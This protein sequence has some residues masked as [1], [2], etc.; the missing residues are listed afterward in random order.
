M[1]QS[2][3]FKIKFPRIDSLTRVKLAILLLLAL[4]ALLSNLSYARL[5]RN[6]KPKAAGQDEVSL[7]EKRFAELRAALPQRGVVGYI[8]DEP[9][10]NEKIKKY[11]LAQYAL[12]P[13]IVVNETDR[14]LVVGNFNSPDGELRASDKLVPFKRFENGVV[15]FV[16]AAK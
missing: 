16:Q 5:T 1:R 14:P 4:N 7:N 2:I 6:L 9:D 8:S 12:A 13:L 3:M 10:P 15:L 11:Y